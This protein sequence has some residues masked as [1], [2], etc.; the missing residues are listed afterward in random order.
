MM[1]YILQPLICL[2]LGTIAFTASAETKP[3]NIV[4][5]LSDD[6]SYTDYSFMGHE[7]IKTPHLDKLAADSL[8]FERGYVAAPL[9]RPSLASMAT[10]LYPFQHG[11]T[12]NDVDARNNRTELDAPVRA[13]FHEYPSFIKLLT[14]N[15]YLAHQSRKWWEGSFADG[16]FTHGMTHGDPERGGRHGD[17]G[18]KIG[19]DGDQA[20]AYLL[21]FEFPDGVQVDGAEDIG[22]D[23]GALGR[24]VVGHR[25][26]KFRFGFRHHRVFLFVRISGWM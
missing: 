20:N 3:P 6:Q 9:C 4:L 2:F 14:T 25:S 26:I 23:V 12:G 13:R 1:K 21:A 22:A 8:V 11:I 7:H 16:G 24:S 15:G 5:I 19:R 18:L 17:L 10:G